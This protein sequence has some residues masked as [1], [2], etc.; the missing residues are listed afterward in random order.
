MNTIVGYNEEDKY[1]IYGNDYEIIEGLR[2]GKLIVKKRVDAPINVKTNKPMGGIWYECQCDCGNVV[3]KRKDNIKAGAL[4]GGPAA[5][6]NKGCRTCGDE[7][8][9]HSGIKQRNTQGLIISH[10]TDT[11]LAGNKILFSTGYIDLSNRSE[12]IICECPHCKQPYPT[13]RRSQ[14]A[15]CGC[16]MHRPIRTLEDYMAQRQCKSKGEQ[17]I[18]DLLIQYNVPFVSEKKFPN[19]KD[20]APLPFDF[21]IQ[22][23]TFGGYVVEFDGEQHFKDIKYFGDFNIRKKHDIIKNKFCWNNGIRIIRIPYNADWNLNDLSLFTTRFE[24]TPQNEKEYY[25]NRG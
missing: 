12:I 2:V 4:R 21:Y 6:K 25:K 15:S 22:S 24:L 3:I 18:Y 8:C 16:K 17:A 20:L 23:P 7:K 11:N 19:C 5:Q 10:H 1:P 9:N 13:T 14:S